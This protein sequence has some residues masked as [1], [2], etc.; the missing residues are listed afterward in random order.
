MFLIRLICLGVLMMVTVVNEE[1]RASLM[2]QFYECF[3]DGYE[4]ERFLKPFLEKLGLKEIVVTKKSNDGGIDL[5]GVRPGLI[6]NEIDSVVYKIQAK[7]FKP[8][9][10]VG[11][12][13]IHRHLGIMN[14]DEVGIIITTGR[15]TKG[16]WD[17][18]RSKLGYKL[19]L[20]D[21][22][23]LIDLCIER[24]IGFV[25]EPKFSLK[26]LKE[27]YHNDDIVAS[28]NNNYI[29]SVDMEITFND[30]RARIFRIP[31]MIMERFPKEQQEFDIC[32][33][34]HCLRN[35]PISK[36]RRYFSRGVSGLY[37]KYGI[38]SDE[39]VIY[40]SKCNWKIDVEG[41]IYVFLDNRG[42]YN[43]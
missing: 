43:F 1:E 12:D 40:P 31:R 30:I 27:F 9:K 42:E 34:G 11:V 18:S 16:A 32:F 39:G 25:Y 23:E 20:I 7:R 22:A 26:G 35:I 28:D 21:G 17:A 3:S 14:A 19:I 38:D 36:D 5:V 33:N 8:D 4:F 24:K 41:N 15:F 6:N 13:V 10:K 37:R 2:R 29:L